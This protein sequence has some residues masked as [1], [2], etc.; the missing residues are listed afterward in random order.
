MR[1]LGRRRVSHRLVV[2]CGCAML[3][4]SAA[5]AETGVKGVE[6]SRQAI[7]PSAGHTVGLAFELSHNDRVSVHVYD[8][9]GGWVRTL[10][11][12]LEGRVG[13]NEVSWDGRDADG[14]VVPDE[15]YHFV[16]ETAS[17]SVYDPTT[18][19]GG[20]VGVVPEAEF[21]FLGGTA[22]YRLPTS[23]RVLARL[24]IRD[25]PML[26]TLVDWKPRV[27]G[28]VT[29][30]WQGWD[31][32]KVIRFAEHPGFLAIITYVS[33]PEASVIAFGN[34][35]ASYRITRLGEAKDRRRKPTRPDSTQ[36]AGRLRPEGLVPPAWSRAPVVSLILPEF[37][38]QDLLVPEVG[39]RVQ[40]RVEIDPAD[41]EQLVSDQFEVMFY[42]DTVF[43]AESERGYSP[44]NWVWETHQL[45]PG[46]HLLTVNV[47]SLK[48]RVGVA[49]RKV[50]IRER[51]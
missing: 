23:A 29:E 47:S 4:V 5:S 24:G 20:V 21:D 3:A 32:D 31:E 14:N 30:Y 9:D 15:A 39:D 33:L 11:D 17:G 36:P 28:S 13:R 37:E 38:T 10:T 34:R 35:E 26:K 50:R 44:L 22:T 43:F 41:L 8:P 1:M 18:F 2:G 7:N 12:S 16:I 51:P 46:E 49:S 40:V 48:G 6:L 25:G 27:A 42:V 45:P 19:S